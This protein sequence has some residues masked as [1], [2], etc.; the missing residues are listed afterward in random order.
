MFTQAKTGDSRRQAKSFAVS[1]GAH[2]LLFAWL[3]YN[4]IP[5]VLV[6]SSVR[7]GQ[8]D[9]AVTQL[10]WPVSG[11]HA[12]AGDLLP[13][14]TTPD[15]QSRKRLTWQKRAKKIKHQKPNPA[16]ARTDAD[17]PTTASTQAG[18]TAPAGMAYGTVGS[19]S[20]SGDEIRPALPVNASD[21]VVDPSDLPSAEGSVIVEVTIDDKGNIVQKTVIESLTPAIDAKVLAAL[22]SWRF[23]PA[24]RNGVAIPSKQ[25]VYYHFRPRA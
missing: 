20:V 11:A 14:A 9:G 1:L 5:K 25:D 4:S 16:P 12:A 13:S 21:P 24:T 22:E 17:T 2:A 3:L 15:E 8:A 18:G 7:A 10:Y 19:G 23:Q 6:P